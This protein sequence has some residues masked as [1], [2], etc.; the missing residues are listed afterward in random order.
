M[1]FKHL[2]ITS[3]ASLIFIVAVTAQEVTN[4][5]VNQNTFDS[6][7]HS[8]GTKRIERL[9]HADKASKLIGMEVKNDLNLELGKISDMALDVESGR[10]IYVIVSSGGFIGIGSTL[11]AVPP[12]LLYYDFTNGVIKFAISQDKF[13]AAPGFDMAK[14]ADCSDSNRVVDVYRYYGENPFFISTNEVNTNAMSPRYRE[15]AASQVHMVLTNGYCHLGQVEK[16]TGVIGMQVVNLQ[17]EKLG[18]V[19][20]LMVD[21]SA[22]RI[23]GVV[24]SSGSY[25][26]IDGELSAVPP[27]AFRFN[28]ERD[29]LQLDASKELLSNAPHFTS[30]QWPDIN[31]PSYAYGMY[32]AYGIDPYFSTNE[33][34]DADNTSRNF[35]DRDDRTLTPLD[36]GNSWSDVNMTAAI[37]KEIMAADGLSIDGRNIKIITI[38]GRVTLR[39]PVDSAEEKRRIDHIAKNIAGQTNVDSQLEVKI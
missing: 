29:I 34:A 20:N 35:R 6:S 39:G 11:H 22:G 25:L 19:E 16:A 10:I 12:Q 18:K 2:I 30:S 38:D 23:V 27:T 13:N 31:Q 14:W 4:P 3:T 15:E 17:D 21:F 32:H 5:T 33:T 8:F 26:G 7:G 28:T 36:Q 24:I 9:G 1:N 37:R